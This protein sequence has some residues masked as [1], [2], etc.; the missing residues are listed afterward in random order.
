MLDVIIV[1][2]YGG[3]ATAKEV[4]AVDWLSGGSTLLRHELSSH[5]HTLSNRDATI[6][7]R[8]SGVKG[9]FPPG[10]SAETGAAEGFFAMPEA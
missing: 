6:H 1:R 9:E 2:G 7:D 3:G 4:A 8:P 10:L 5:L